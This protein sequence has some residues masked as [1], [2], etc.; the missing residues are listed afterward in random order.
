MK[1]PREILERLLADR[2]LGALDPDVESLLEAY[3]A[4]DPDLRKLAHEFGH[5]VALAR[6]AVEATRPSI[7]TDLPQLKLGPAPKAR[8]VRLWLLGIRAATLAACLAIGLLLGVTLFRNTA[9]QVPSQL[10]SL[11][12]L[13][14]AESTASADTTSQFWS[15]RQ[16]RGLAASRVPEHV[17]AV[18][19][20]WP[21]GIEEQG[22]KP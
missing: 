5:T 12:P 4:H 3:L 19:W 15:I 6:R 18:K 2:A 20:S 1:V 10:P 22:D 17:P 14:L 21:V 11:P 7:P 13:V 16:F 9:A 8:G